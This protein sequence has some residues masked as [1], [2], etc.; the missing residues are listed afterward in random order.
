MFNIIK[1]TPKTIKTIKTVGKAAIYGASVTVAA[2]GGF[3]LGRF[4]GFLEGVLRTKTVL[5]EDWEENK[6]ENIKRARVDYVKH[7][8]N[9]NQEDI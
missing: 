1:I 5:E 8:K 3:S 9:Y 7:L 6:H 4:M 2:R